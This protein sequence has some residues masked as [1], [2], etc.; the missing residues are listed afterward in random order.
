MS[1]SFDAPNELV[2]S[3][4]EKKRTDILVAGKQITIQNEIDSRNRAPRTR[5]LKYSIDKE[6]YSLELK[7]GEETSFDLRASSHQGFRFTRVQGRAWQLPGPIKS[8]AFPDQVRTYYQNAG[9]LSDLEA[10]YESQMDHTFYLGPLRDY[11]K[12][13]YVW[14]RSLLT[15]ANAEK[16]Q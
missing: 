7:E 9:F 2:I 6:S 11:P 10:A 8:Y 1:L 3:D 14:T 13:E 15:L 16:E 12:R 5:N 4:P